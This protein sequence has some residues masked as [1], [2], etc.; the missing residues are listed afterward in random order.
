MTPKSHVSFALRVYLERFPDEQPALVALAAQLND[1]TFT[2]LTARSNMRGHLTS[3]ALVLDPV[4]GRV[5]LIY[6][7]LANRWLQPGGHFDP[8]SATGYSTSLADSA[9]R[10]VEEETGLRGAEL[11][12]L[13]EGAGYLLDV[14]THDIKANPRKN[15]GAH[16]HHDFLYLATADSNAPLKAQETEVSCARW[17]DLS[18]LKDNPN[19]RFARVYQKLVRFGFAK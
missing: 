1:E 10:E 14:D 17:E 9:L 16:V 5:L 4:K 6:H 11:Q 15:E 7:I 13:A 12:Q 8:I 2:Q 19:P 3:S 18:V